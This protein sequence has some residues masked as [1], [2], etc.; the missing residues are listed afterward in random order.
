MLLRNLNIRISWFKFG[1]EWGSWSL[2]QY[3]LKWKLIFYF[4]EIKKLRY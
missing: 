3:P 1:R 2:S 4:I